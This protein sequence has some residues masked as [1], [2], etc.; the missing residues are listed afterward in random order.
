VTGKLDPDT[1]N[2]LPVTA[3]EFTVTGAVP[4]DVK[5]TVWVDCV[6]TGTEPNEMFVALTVS[7]GVCVDVDPEGVNWIP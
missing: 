1:E 2:P 5:V 6:F 4:L 7:V 3:A